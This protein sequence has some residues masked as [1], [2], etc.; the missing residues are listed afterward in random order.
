LLALALVACGGAGEPRTTTTELPL[1]GSGS[2]SDSSIACGAGTDVT[3][4]ISG[5]NIVDANPSDIMFIVDGSGSIGPS[6]FQQ[7]RNFMADVVNQLPVDADHRI[8]IV[9]FANSAVLNQTFSGDK[10]TVLAKIATLPYPSGLTCTECGL[11]VATAEF[12]ARSPASAHRIG[13]V[14][15][16]GVATSPANLPAALAAAAAQNIELF[17]IGVGPSISMAQLN[18]IASDPDATHVFT[19]ASY[20][21]LHTILQALV[22][23]VTRPE[24]TNATLVLNISSD[25]V[26]SAPVASGG[27][28]AQ[29]SNVLTWQVDSILDHTYALS[30]HVEH[31]SSTSWGTLPIIASYAY[32]D[33][34]GNDLALPELT[35]D[36]VTC[37]RDGD[38]EPDTTDNCPDHANPDQ[39]D[40]DG[41][42]IGDACDDDI[43]GDGVPN[44]DDNCVTTPNSD[45]A[46]QDGDGIGDACD[47]DVD[48]DGVPNTDDNCVTTPNPSQSDLDDDGIGD[49]CDSDIDGD[50]VP[51][52]DDNCPLVANP[53]QDDADGDG[54]GDAC[55]TDD[56]NDGVDDGA[57]Q[58]P[59]TPAGTIVDANGCSIDQHCP[60]NSNWQ[61]HGKYVSCVAKA[62]DAFVLAGLITAAQKNAIVSAAAQSS[63]GK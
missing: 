2:V 58:C 47:D 49:A 32:T 16:D 23:A 18:Q 55:D 1:T 50:G 63:C 60:C 20:A 51:N 56:D 21:N 30:F 31:A 48:G 57:D 26:A 17:A 35:V 59:G 19:V 33:D 10:A 7:A 13:I 5:T 41:D 40:Q 53:G 24:A 4:S 14:L 9:T 3:L 37:D 27:T 54:V 38:G 42:G 43:D 22:A 15:T 25:F 44:A 62:A 11:N 6:A 52:G 39:A 28:F 45:Q 29:A 61:N 8:G 36:V 34:E 46:D 12:A